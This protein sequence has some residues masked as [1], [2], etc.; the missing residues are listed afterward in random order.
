MRY[1]YNKTKRHYA[2]TFSITTVA[3]VILMLTAYYMASFNNATGCQVTKAL[4]PN[5]NT[6]ISR[7][8]AV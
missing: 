5:G 4:T 8:Q 1:T 7:G 2:T 6:V 3:V